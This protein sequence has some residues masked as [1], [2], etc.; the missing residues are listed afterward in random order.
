MKL[1]SKKIDLLVKLSYVKQILCLPF[2]YMGIKP[3][4]EVL[5]L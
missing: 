5:N 2:Q 4:K 3:D 1:F